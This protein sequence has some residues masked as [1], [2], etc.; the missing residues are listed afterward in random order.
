MAFDPITAGIELGK[1]VL[2]MLTPWIPD[3]VA[4][5]KA[6]QEMVSLLL[7]EKRLDN[8]DRDSARKREM[9]VKDATPAR[10][11]FLIV[12]SFIAVA[13]FV[14]MHPYVWPGTK[15]EP[16]MLGMVGAVIGYLSAKAEQVASYY[17]GSSAGSQAKDSVIKNITSSK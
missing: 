14:V 3:P 8:Q 16:E 4:R 12:G 11:A 10:L 7:E 15:L 6:A 5:E 13:L 17:F 1:K 9:E 2:D